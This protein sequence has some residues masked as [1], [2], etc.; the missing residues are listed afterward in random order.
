[1]LHVFSAVQYAGFTITPVIGA[2]LS[3]FAY[4]S[5]SYTDDTF[6]N[7]YSIP[8]LFQLCSA[9]LCVLLLLT[10]FKEAYRS[11]FDQTSCSE[12]K[13]ADEERK[14]LRMVNNNI[15]LFFSCATVP[16]LQH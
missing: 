6:V 15:L 7:Q 9:G 16:H 1:M 10:V 14:A 5:T 4:N 2:A 11:S 3:A 12:T 8:A 13:T